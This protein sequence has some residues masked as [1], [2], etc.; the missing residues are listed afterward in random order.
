[1]ITS[2]TVR[3]PATSGTT[4]A[5]TSPPRCERACERAAVCGCWLAHA[6][7]IAESASSWSP[8]RPG[9][10]RPGRAPPAARR[11]WPTAP[12]PGR[13]GPTARSSSSRCS[14]MPPGSR[15][16]PGSC[17]ATLRSW[18]SRRVASAYGCGLPASPRACMTRCSVPAASVPSDGEDQPLRRR[19]PG[20]PAGRSAAGRRRRGRCSRR[21]SARSAATP[22]S[23]A[24]SRERRCSAATVSGTAR[25]GQQRRRRPARSRPCRPCRRPRR[26][27]SRRARR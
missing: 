25:Y 17:R 18:V 6:S 23:A 1:M 13:R 21:R 7:A 16:A 11:R 9:R 20:S 4:S 19:P 5:E 3:T 8:S 2:P 10:R 22:S 12:R 14:E 26:P 27:G 24:P 15:V